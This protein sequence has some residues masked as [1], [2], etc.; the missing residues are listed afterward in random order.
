VVEA[1]VQGMSRHADWA[2]KQRSRDFLTD[3]DVKEL[4][5]LRVK[6]DEEAWALD[7]SA[8]STKT[9]SRVNRLKLVGSDCHFP[10][11]CPQTWRLFL[12]AIIDLDPDD[13][14]LLGDFMDLESCSSHG[15]TGADGI[16]DVMDE[17]VYTQ[18]RLAQVD[19]ALARA[20]KKYRKGKPKPGRRKRL[21]MGNHEARFK[22]AKGGINPVWRRTID[23]LPEMLGLAESGWEWSEIPPEVDW[24]TGKKRKGTQ[25]VKEAGGEVF[26][27]HGESF[28]VNHARTQAVKHA[29]SQV[30]G[31][32]H[33]CQQTYLTYPDPDTGDMT[34]TVHVT[35]LPCMCRLFAP[36]TAQP[37]FSDWT[38]GWGVV[39]AMGNHRFVYPVVVRRDKDW[40]AHAAYGR[41][42]WSVGNDE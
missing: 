20:D 11:E 12:Q 17:C 8:S 13:L 28:S 18:R 26:W 2:K 31:H 15:S 32:T 21:W 4:H 40:T 9:R 34:R 36:W 25:P 19:E 1:K 24:R 7:F 23:S 33:R 42:R 39:E 30:Y 41:W 35:G 22:K 29:V 37:G 14:D 38:N 3:N 27:H 5:E 10:N 16:F 6:R